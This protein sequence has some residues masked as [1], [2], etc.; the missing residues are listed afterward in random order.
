M[1]KCCRES[2]EF[3]GKYHTYVGCDERDSAESSDIE[4]NL[5]NEGRQAMSL[6]RPTLQRLTELLG[7]ARDN[8]SF[9]H[10]LSSRSAFCCRYF[11]V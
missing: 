7:N 1:L 9:R 5:K 10:K 8:F 6:E 2:K 3:D 11:S 4:N